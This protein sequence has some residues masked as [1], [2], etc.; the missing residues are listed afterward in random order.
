MKQSTE[1]KFTFSAIEEVHQYLF[2][3]P[4]FATS[5][6][7]AARWG[8]QGIRQLCSFMGDPQQELKVVHIAGTNGKGTVAHYISEVLQQNRYRVGLYTSPHLQKVNE[9]WKTDGVDMTD[10]ELLKLFQQY[11]EAIVSTE[12]TFFELT[13]ALAFRHFADSNVDFA[14]IETGLG[15]RLDATNIVDPV[16]SIITSIGLDHQAVLG[17]SIEEI[18]AEKAGIIKPGRPVIIGNLQEAAESVVTEAAARNSAELIKSESSDY[19]Y[20]STENDPGIQ[21]A[22]VALNYLSRLYSIDKH[23]LPLQLS[24][25]KE[26][27]QGRFEKLHPQYS[28]YF[29]GAHNTAAVDLMRKKLNAIGS[30]SY[31]TVVLSVMKDKANKDFL[32]LFSD[33]RKIYYY[34]LQFERAAP[35]N[36]IAPLTDQSVEL[37]PQQSHSRDRLLKSLKSELVIFTGSFYFY[38]CVKGWMRSF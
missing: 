26:S 19:E 32:G 36:E 38:N 11:G 21:V 3:I 6:A 22:G 2:S 35:L 33:F 5:G 12:P 23:V 1:E 29:D 27:L 24:E 37:F 31:A 34:P 28:W 9:R 16:L 10:D 8:L 14:V 30:I 13:T 15:G 25:A 4:M 18:A 20:G 17:N 7:A